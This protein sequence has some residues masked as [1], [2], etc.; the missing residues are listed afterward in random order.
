VKSKGKTPKDFIG[1]SESRFEKAEESLIKWRKRRE[2]PGE[3]GERVSKEA[4]VP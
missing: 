2:A 3:T 4:S 1:N